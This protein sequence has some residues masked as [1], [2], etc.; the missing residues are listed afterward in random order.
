M[1]AQSLGTLNSVAVGDTFETGVSPFYKQSEAVCFVDCNA[2]VG[3]VLVQTLL[4]A[5]WS[6]EKTITLAAASDVTVMVNI[7]DVNDGVR[8]NMTVRTGGAVEA[9]LLG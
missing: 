2:F 5:V 8:I 6:T 9:H 4:G 3:T 7:D 1:K